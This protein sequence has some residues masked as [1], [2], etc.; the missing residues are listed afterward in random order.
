MSSVIG[1][2]RIGGSKRVKEKYSY[3]SVAWNSLQP[4]NNT[5]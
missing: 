2:H 4:A 3:A 5:I 1:D